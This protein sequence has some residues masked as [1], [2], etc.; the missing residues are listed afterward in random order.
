MSKKNRRAARRARKA[1]SRQPLR[2][3]TVA[4]SVLGAVKEAWELAEWLLKV[5]R[6]LR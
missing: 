3:V 1:L 2:I 5:I 6:Y 4:A